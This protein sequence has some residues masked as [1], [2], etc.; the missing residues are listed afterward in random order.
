VSNEDLGP[1]GFPIRPI[2]ALNPFQQRW[3]IKARCVHKEQVHTFQ[4]ETGEGK[5]SSVELLDSSGEIKATMFGE[6][7]DECLHLFQVG[8]VYFVAKGKVKQTQSKFASTINQFEITLNK[9]S[10]IQECTEA[11]SADVPKEMYKCVKIAQL[12]QCAENE[13]VDIVGIVREATDIIEITSKN[14]KHLKKRDLTISDD[15]GSVLLSLW[16]TQAESWTMNEFPVLIGIKNCRVKTFN[17][18]VLG[19]GDGFRYELSPTTPAAAELQ[20]WYEKQE[21]VDVFGSL[22]FPFSNAKIRLFFSR[23]WPHARYVNY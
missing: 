18:K 11:E 15:T 5:V 16:N 20:D 10:F 8:N 12:N 9:G 4:K 19:T 23:Y 21:T 14:G 2:S 3:M 1:D 17:G 7:V 22:P 6:A 13:S